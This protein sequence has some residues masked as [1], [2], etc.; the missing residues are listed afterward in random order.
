[1]FCQHCGAHLRIGGRFCA[2]CGTAVGTGERHFC[3]DCGVALEPGQ[4]VCSVC[5]RILSGCPSHLGRS[6][7][8]RTT[9][10]MLG[11]LAGAFGVHNFYLGRVGR[12]LVQ[13]LVSVC[14][15]GLG[16]VPMWIWGIID[17]ILIFKG[18]GG[19][20]IDA[21]GARLAD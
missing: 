12:G 3:P 6:I 19:Y 13:V 16:F 5:R 21:H 17:G 8:S 1:M 7:K 11:L 4:A 15:C 10:G 18:C 2:M 14:T 9:A 20:A